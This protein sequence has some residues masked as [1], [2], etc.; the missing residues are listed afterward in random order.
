MFRKLDG[1]MPLGLRDPEV[2][3]L[4]SCDWQIYVSCDGCLWEERWDADFGA[5]PDELPKCRKCGRGGPRR[6]VRHLFSV[7][8]MCRE[9]DA[10]NELIAL[11]LADLQCRQCSSRYLVLYGFKI[12]PPFPSE[13]GEAMPQKKESWG[14][15]GTADGT[16][17]VSQLQTFNQLPDRALHFLP[18][19]RLCERLRW[20]C[21][22][23]TDDDLGLI[24]NVEGNLLREYFRETKDVSAGV[25]ALEAFGESRR[26]TSEP[27][28]RALVEHNEAMCCYS[29]LAKED[30]AIL[31]ARG[32]PSDL[33]ERGVQHAL[34]ALVVFD[35]GAGSG[36][37][38]SAAQAARIRFLLG[39]L[40]QVGSP[41]NDRLL[42]AIAHYDAAAGEPSTD[43]RTRAWIRARR[44]EALLKTR[45]PPKRERDRA[46]AEL[47]AMAARPETDRAFSEKW[48]I[49]GNIGSLYLSM[50]QLTRAREKFEYAGALAL[51]DIESVTDDGT[52][53]A[54]AGLYAQVF[55]AL[56]RVYTAEG[57][58]LEALAAMETIR[59]AALAV[60]LRPLEEKE[61]FQKAAAAATIKR[62]MS[63]LLGEG[64]SHASVHELS[65]NLSQTRDACRRFMSSTEH[66]ALV[67]LSVFSGHVSAVIAL[68]G[69]KGE[70][71]FEALEW[72]ISGEEFET[73]ENYHLVFEA[74]PLRERRLQRFCS[75]LSRVVLGSIP[76]VLQREDLSKVTFCLPGILSHWPLE[77]CRLAGDEV[78]GAR[79]GC[80]YIPSIGVAE[81]LCDSQAKPVPRKILVV[82]YLG[83]D[84]DET[85]R[86]VE[87]VRRIGGD[88]VDVLTGEGL[89]KH[90]LLDMMTGEYGYLH[91]IC[92]GTFD[93]LDPLESALDLNRERPGDAFKLRAR[94]L[95]NVDLSARPVVTMSACSSSLTSF[96][97]A[98]T[99]TGLSGA[100]LRAGAR[101]VVGGRWDVFDDTGCAFMT[102]LYELMFGDNLSV[103]ESVRRTQDEFR[104]AR[105][106]EDWA[107]FS[108]L[109]VP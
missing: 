53:D 95:L 90:K 11:D 50:G 63:G 36:Q 6:V 15:S 29:L 7:E 40:L 66:A 5:P 35:T 94:D 86:E 38:Y 92:H 97:R 105:P 49:I 17:I 22:Y 21:K 67:A 89:T 10:W 100:L 24:W 77:A 32:A 85:S 71:R 104:R 34:A 42:Q 57:R 30:Q 19:I 93:V 65:L 33:R 44:S 91:F 1:Q 2:L 74:S 13:F 99:F 55:D 43:A 75:T 4:L 39:D 28:Q 45:N 31:T 88:R 9:C 84:L 101:A 69:K 87:A 80:S 73:L 106:I 107:S 60:R 109:G 3:P 37:P 98:N 18:L 108:L 52:L 96:D 27:V 47:E 79:Y 62:V 102:R 12:A 51:Y 26:L 64:P 25:A 103:A 16:F 78:L 72:A 46:I 41:T 68:P 58:S 81:S 70:P 20:A 56:F 76:D 23:P 54:R 8:A 48:P 83:T 82:P 61:A 14:N 59:A